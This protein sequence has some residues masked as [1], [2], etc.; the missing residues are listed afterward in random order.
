[1]QFY[2]KPPTQQ[3]I[4]D[5]KGQHAKENSSKQVTSPSSALL[6]RLSQ[7][8]SPFK[9]HIQEVL[10]KWTQ[11]DDEIWAKV[12][13]FERN[14]RVAKAYAR[15]PVLTINASDIYRQE[16]HPLLLLTYEANKREHSMLYSHIYTF[17][18]IM[19]SNFNSNYTK[20]LLNKKR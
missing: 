13:V 3:K 9:E 18:T 7:I 8:N 16:Y 20:T 5:V 2:A 4:S 14:R 1:M 17:T 11:I 6:R 12:I 19:K 15:A 10:D